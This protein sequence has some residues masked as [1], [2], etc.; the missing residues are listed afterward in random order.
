[1]KT[2][3]LRILKCV[4][5]IAIAL[6]M[7]YFLTILHI[8]KWLENRWHPS[9]TNTT[10]YKL[11]E[12]SLDVVFMGSSVMSAAVNPYQL[13][14]DYGISSYNLAIMQ[15]PMIG[16]Y[17]WLKEVL[18]TQSPS[19][20]VLE[21]KTAG[22]V[23]D[24]NEADARK[25]YDY[26]K[27]G[28]NKLQYAIEYCEI[29]EDSIIS[30]YLFPIAKYHSRWSSLSEE[31]FEYVL[32]DNKTYTR[33][34]ATLTTK[35]K[36]DLEPIDTNAEL[37]E[38]KYNATNEAY[39]KKIV[40]LCREND[41][42]IIFTKTPDAGWSGTKY[43]HV[44]SLAEEFDVPYLDFNTEELLK[45]TNFDY[46]NDA[47][48]EVHLNI[49]GA[50]KITKYF[51]EYLSENYEISDKR[52]DER[53][54]AIY[55]EGRNMYEHTYADAKLCMWYNMDSFFEALD[56]EHY[57]FILT[58]GV[59]P[60]ELSDD[61]CEKLENLGF[62]EKTIK[63][64]TE[65]N[66]NVIEVIKAKQNVAISSE[67]TEEELSIKEDGLF[68]DGEVYKVT[69]KAGACSIKVDQQE[70]VVDDNKINLLIYNNVT[71]KVADCVCFNVAED[72]T[73]TVSR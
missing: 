62:S 47:A 26:M 19:V 36:L 73:V 32:G 28:K 69:A 24:K 52:E 34:L 30:E 33:G 31:D 22:R 46:A 7:I 21:V 3:I 35:Y 15:Q 39:V 50:E 59:N 72:G 12:D 58:N 70:Y 67:I 2:K 6:G 16:S 63:K 29:T 25:S 38:D 71:H 20:V 56:K 55:E 17:F 61:I 44:K 9:K 64:L 49:L 13:Y 51:G 37:I 60:V 10:F 66:T 1:M 43:A 65:E 48:E 14:D 45:A 8:P 57:S 41:I 54:S 5:F 23:S 53:I 11:E 27:W 68:K 18:E 4:F 42:E 40:D